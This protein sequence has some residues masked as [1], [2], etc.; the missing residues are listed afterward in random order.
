MVD[1]TKAIW[2]NDRGSELSR[3]G[4]RFVGG[5]G[6]RNEFIEAVVFS[7]SFDNGAE[8][9]ELDRKEIP[10]SISFTNEGNIVLVNIGKPFSRFNETQSNLAIRT[11]IQRAANIC[12]GKTFIVNNR[13]QQQDKSA[14]EIEEILKG[15]SGKSKAEMLQVMKEFE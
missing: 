4:L 10:L 2:L 7:G 6:Y 5:D 15:L 13:C 12:N 1:Y 3:N 11:I 9:V 14:E 8:T